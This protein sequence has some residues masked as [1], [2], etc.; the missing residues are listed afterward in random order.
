[1]QLW[2]R[3]VIAS[4]RV[5]PAC[6]PPFVPPPI[7]SEENL[8][9]LARVMERIT[10]QTA[11]GGV[12]HDGKGCPC[13]GAWAQVLGIYPWSETRTQEGIVRCSASWDDRNFGTPHPSGIGITGRVIRYRIRRP[14]ALLKLIK[15]AENLPDRMP[16]KEDA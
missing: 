1:M 6:T 11:A 3:S 16:V 9:G 5:S 7:Y 4:K 2:P 14:R 8:A 13:K 15:M 10:R 12:E